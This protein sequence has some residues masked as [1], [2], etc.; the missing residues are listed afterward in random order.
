M[1]KRTSAPSGNPTPGGIL[2][3]PLATFTIHVILH[4]PLMA[5][6]NASV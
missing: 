4:G 5:V 2:I 3:V 1:F 6:G